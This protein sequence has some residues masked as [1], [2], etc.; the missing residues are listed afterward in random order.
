[1]GDPRASSG[2]ITADGN[3]NLTGTE[4]TKYQGVV[5]SN[6]AVTGTYKVNANCTGT[7]TLTPSISPAITYSFVILS[8]K[9]TIQI[10]D[11][12]KLRTQSGYAISQGTPTCS[13]AGLKGTYGFQGGSVGLT[14]PGS[15]TG[16]MVLDGAGN[17]TGIETASMNGQIFTGIPLTGTY[18]MNSNCQGTASLIAPGLPTINLALVVASS[19]QTIVAME[20]DQMSTLVGSIQKAGTAA[21]SNSTLKGVYSLLEGGAFNTSEY[22]ATSNQLTADGAG[23]LTGIQTSS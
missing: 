21:C 7:G 6:V 16:Q 22:A 23:N 9:K 2:Q 19:G 17:L 12:D 15:G 14:N 11:T 5:Y 1:M 13:T 8:D 20:T 10:L 3:G 18:S 4:T